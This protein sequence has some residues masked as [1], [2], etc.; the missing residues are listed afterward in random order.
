MGSK[1]DYSRFMIMRIQSNEKHTENNTY[2]SLVGII[3][4]AIIKYVTRL[5]IDDPKSYRK[6]S[7]E[8]LYKEVMRVVEAVIAE[9]SDISE[10]T[11]RKLTNRFT[12]G[13][14]KA[15]LKPKAEQE[16]KKILGSKTSPENR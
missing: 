15:F 14:L 1:P 3:Q 12:L 16:A 6:K 10:E 7:D 11:K 8:D 9:H 2:N 5:Y 4:L 13:A